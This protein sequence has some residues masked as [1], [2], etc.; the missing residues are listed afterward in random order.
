[1][2]RWTLRLAAVISLVWIAFAVSP[3][4]ALYD[5]ARAVERRDEPAIEA[6]ANLRA[7]RSSLA[8]Q[9]VAAYLEAFGAGRELDPSFRQ[10]AGEAATGIVEPVL[11][12]LVTARGILDLLDDGWPQG[13][14]LEGAAAAGGLSREALRNPWRVF[15]DSRSRGFRT[16]YF[17]FPLDRPPEQRFRVQL[18][19]VNWTWRL[20]EVELPLALRRA[21]VQRLPKVRALSDRT[22][23][24]ESPIGL[25]LRLEER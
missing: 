8:R 25:R 3:Y 22:L 15:L 7:I 24:G 5:L 4:V 2:V 21:L 19:L 12:S 18:R 14:A 23:M 9:I 6:R 17:A 1:M 13:L 11:E 16:S 20:V 10:L